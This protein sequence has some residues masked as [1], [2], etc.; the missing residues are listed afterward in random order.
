MTDWAAEFSATKFCHGLSDPPRCHHHGRT[1]MTWRAASNGVRQHRR[2]CLDCGEPASNW[3]TRETAMKETIYPWDDD[4]MHR[5]SR[6][7][8]DAV[9]RSRA[10]WWDVYE[11]YLASEDWGDRRL[12]VLKRDHY[13][14]QGCL[15]EPATQVH[16]LT[17]KHV[18]REPL[19]DLVGIC[20]NCHDMV[21]DRGDMAVF[22]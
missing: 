17:Y 3:V 15:F 6:S 1:V 21:H 7:V 10:Q 20:E 8:N 16:H 9:Q 2:Q 5:F 4:L 19:F 22:T 13:I 14:C 12:A 18:G 11:R